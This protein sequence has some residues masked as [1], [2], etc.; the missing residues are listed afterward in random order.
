MS[1]VPMP[2][3]LA[4]PSSRATTRPKAHGRCV[5]ARSWCVTWCLLALSLVLPGSAGASPLSLGYFDQ[6]FT[7]AT[8]ERTPW[9][10]RAV[11]S[12]ADVLRID[13]GW[14]EL[15][16]PT[17]PADANDPADPAYDFRKA[18]DAIIDAKGRGLRVVVSFA[19]APTWA[20][21]P[22]RPATAVPGSWKPDPAAI[23]RYGTALA[24]R[25]SGTYPDPARPG[26]KLPRVDAFQLWNEP[27]LTEYLSPQWIN[28]RTFAPIHYRLMLNAFYRGVKGTGSTARVVTGGTAPYGDAFDFARGQ[29]IRPAR[30]L[31]EMLCLSEIKGRLRGTSCPDPARFDVLSHHPYS[32]GA[33][34]RAADHP[35]DVS[36]PDLGKLNRLLRAA[37]RS[38]RVFPR[39]RHR[40][41]VT[42][43]SYD[44]APPDS[45]GVPL[46]RHARWLQETLYLLWR[47]GVDTILWFQ[48]RDAPTDD[49]QALNQSGTYFRGGAPKPAA[50][51]L[52]FPFVAEQAAP[53][54]LRIW[55]RAPKSGPVR[56]QKGTPKGWRTVR[57][58][59]GTRHGVFLAR[60]PARG[61]TRLRARNAGHTSL[62][63]TS[64]PP[65]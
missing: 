56:I 51:G 22:G 8:E 5:I 7:T 42:E 55:G 14:A 1:T 37:E 15:T 46:I 26:R 49:T 11:G 13:I 38:G 28:R 45:N 33:P 53:G 31:R 40:L 2:P 52:L 6:V 18:D 9:L 36:I 35:D 21:G 63:W 50:L 17:P 43:V 34:R 19:R 48:V 62:T 64:N 29:R 27:N 10:D 59:P 32:I 54:V 20:E 57:T 24:R 58:V 3:I 41:W 60:I 44:S 65:R 16:A 23:G 12:G 47:Q 4:T 25:Y 61:P 30:F 39:I